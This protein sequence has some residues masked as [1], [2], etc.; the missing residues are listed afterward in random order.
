MYKKVTGYCPVLD[1]N[2]SIRVNYREIST[3]AFHG[4]IKDTFRCEYNVSRCICPMP[5]CPIYTSA[6]ETL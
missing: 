5:D 3:S 2:Y 1:E 4:C 6:P